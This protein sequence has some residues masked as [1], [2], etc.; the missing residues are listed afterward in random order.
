VT[1][2]AKGLLL[3][4]ALSILGVYAS[5]YAWLE[6]RIGHDTAG[7]AFGSVTFYYA[8]ALKNGRTEI[9]YDQPQTEIC[10]QAL[11]PHAGYRPCWY[12]AKSQVRIVLLKEP[13]AVR[14]ARSASAQSR[15]MR[16]ARPPSRLPARA[17]AIGPSRRR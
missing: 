7:Q 4:A 2:V 10:V 1:L 9:F 15:A 12:A 16:W 8:T 11:F 14:S 17:A 3:A 6:Y 5:D 13:L